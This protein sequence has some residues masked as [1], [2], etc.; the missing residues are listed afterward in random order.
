MNEKVEKVPA[1]REKG[2]LFPVSQKVFIIASVTWAGICLTCFCVLLYLDTEIQFNWAGEWGSRDTN[3]FCE[4]KKEEGLLGQRFNSVSNFGFFFS[5]GIALALQIT[6]VFLKDENLVS[7]EITQGW[8]YG[9]LMGLGQIY[10]GVGSFL[11]HAHPNWKTHEHD[12]AAM[13][14]YLLFRKNK[15]VNLLFKVTTCLCFGIILLIVYHPDIGVQRGRASGVVGGIVGG[16]FF[17]AL[18]NFVVRN[19]RVI[20]ILQTK[21][22][23][24]LYFQTQTCLDSR[25]FSAVS[26]SFGVAV[27]FQEQFINLP[28]Y[29]NSKFQFHAAWHGLCA[30]GFFFVYLTVR[31]ETLK[32]REY[33]LFKSAS[34]S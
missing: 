27:F 21:T 34:K 2:Y 10:L 26:A 11:F 7:N 6:D 24:I 30:V 12:Q 14:C 4:K 28:C 22:D 16:I 20:N 5:G 32:D 15:I 25:V 19:E 1:Q 18:L 31:F 29:R 9:T 13:F 8:F 33:V 23:K 3:I 17:F